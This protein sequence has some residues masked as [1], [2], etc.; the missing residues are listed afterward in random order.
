MEN[1]ERIEMDEF[2]RE[3]GL[4]ELLPVSLIEDLFKELDHAI[5]ASVLFADGTLYFGFTDM[6]RHFAAGQIQA[7]SNHTSDKLKGSIIIEDGAALF[8]LLHELEAAGFLFLK[9]KKGNIIKMETVVRTGRYTVKCLNFIMEGIYKNL[10]TSGLHG[11]V[12]EESYSQLKQKALALEKSEKKYR[13][14]AENLEIEVE[15][16]TCAFRKAQMQ[17]LRQ[18]KMA[19]IG[20][21]AAGM[22]HEINNPIGFIISNL[23][24]LKENSKDI[25]TMIGHYNGFKKSVEQSF[26]NNTDKNDILSMIK[27]LDDVDRRLDMEFIMEDIQ[28]L[29]DESMDGANRISTIVKDLKDFARPSID[30]PEVVDL[31]E[32][33]AITLSM[34]KEKIGKEVVIEKSYEKI[35]GICCFQREI[36]Q[37]LLNVLLNALYAVGDKG[38]IKIIT[39]SWDQMVE[40]CIQDNGVGIKKEDINRIFDPFFTTKPV[41]TGTGLGLNLTYNIIK[42]HNGKIEVESTKDRGTRFYIKLPVQAIKVT[43]C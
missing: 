5:D 39:R 2:D 19:S 10:M 35:P 15:K 9:R 16:K 21:L 14:L 37:A 41:G 34:V 18:E 11:Q 24:T 43:D 28:N 20:Q 40:V 30:S 32:S 31:N 17:I 29:V 1:H 26:E 36:N 6:P 33:I 23:N 4:E 8:P 13:R 12:V 27:A 42:R 22:A 38:R 25:D 3:Y 7:L